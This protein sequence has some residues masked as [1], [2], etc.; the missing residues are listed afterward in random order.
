[1]RDRFLPRCLRF[2]KNP[3]SCLRRYK[4]IKTRELMH[5]L[6]GRFAKTRIIATTTLIAAPR[7]FT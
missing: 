5:F 7:T 2:S 6:S 1:M 4:E 3:P